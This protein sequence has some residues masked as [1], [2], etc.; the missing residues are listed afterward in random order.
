M[1]SMLLVFIGATF[2][3]SGL[4]KL[5]A[6][7][8]A[9]RFLHDI[10]VPRRLVRSVDR[11][12]SLVEIVLGA[13]LL[14]GRSAWWSGIA[15][16]V[17]AAVFLA[18]HFVARLRGSSVPCGCFGAMDSDLGPVLSMLRS[19][20]LFG[21]TVALVSILYFGTGTVAVPVGHIQ[22]LLG[23][24]LSC[25][26]YLLAFRLLNEAAAMVRRDQEA[27]RRLLAWA[28]QFDES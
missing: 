11:G 18:A 27:H 9:N 2:I 15:A 24:V 1:V 25:A 4:G 14:S 12:V 10:G 7:E 26:T 16:V 19:A 3:V 22:A 23:G 5:R 17:L 8:P 20:V 6:D 13:V 28:A 21:V